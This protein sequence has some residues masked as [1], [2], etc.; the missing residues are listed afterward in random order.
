ML[1]DHPGQ[2]DQEESSRV[3]YLS[4]VHPSVD[5]TVSRKLEEDKSQRKPRFVSISVTVLG[6]KEMVMEVLG[7]DITVGQVKTVI[8]EEGNMEKNRRMSMA[9]VSEKSDLLDGSIVVNGE[10]KE[11]EHVTD[12]AVPKDAV[13]EWPENKPT[14]YLYFIRYRSYEDL[15]LKTKIEHADR[16]VQRKTQARIQITEALRE[17]RSE[18]ADLISQL[19][20]LQEEERQFR[21]V[22]D[23]KRKE[24]EPLQTALG[25]LRGAKNVATEKG[26]G[27]CSSEEELNETIHSLQ[28]CIQHESNTLAMEKQLLKEIKQLEASREKVIANAALRTKIQE[29]FGQKDA[30]Q[31]QVKLI[32]ADLDGARKE[33]QAV[34]AKIQ[35]LE[36]KL[37]SVRAELDSLQTELVSINETR[38]KAYQTFTLLRKERDESNACFFQYRSLM[39]NVKGLAISK[40]ISA[41]KE[42]SLNEVE[43]FMTQW[44]SSKAFRDDY[45]K[46]ILS[47]LDARQLSRDGRMRNP[48]EK[49][50]LSVAPSSIEP[51]KESAKASIEKFEAEK[52][53]AKTST[54]KEKG[55]VIPPRHEAVTSRRTR[56]ETTVKPVE[57]AVV[58]KQVPEAENPSAADK[59]PKE[60]SESNEIDPTKLKEMKREEEIAKAKSAMERK[61]KLAEKAASKA[62][63]KEKKARKKAGVSSQPADAEQSET[64]TKDAEPELQEETNVNTETPA[65]EKGKDQFKEKS[66]RSRGRAKGQNQMPKVL[67]KKKKQHSY[68]L[69]AVPAAIC[70][71]LL[72]VIGFYYSLG[73]RLL[74]GSI[75]A[76]TSLHIGIINTLSL[77]T[78]FS[79]VC[80]RFAVVA[81]AAGYKHHLFSFLSLTLIQWNFEIFVVCLFYSLKYVMLK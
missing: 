44:S 65:P 73:L 30:I 77:D 16:E 52:V 13:D 19:K 25:K 6:E 59:F 33:Q 68:W 61:K 46:R 58:L 78:W 18:K 47:S 63:E 41:L 38:D 15:K 72:V 8:D 29:S 37:N 57:V 11:V 27:L 50:I 1:D 76:D 22:M 40:N 3:W 62:A 32:G 53:P 75:L 23:G 7:A 80:G 31:D 43:K 71:L 9:D 17:K 70:A 12:S 39:N 48:D 36:E 49:P 14:H 45:E 35:H 42:L 21:V 2:S 66:I 5:S 10:T 24:M 54:T 34:R 28:Y 55:N 20:P 79:V 64:E 56:E 51:E 67:L 26:V 60:H 81:S 4:W 69:W 74:L